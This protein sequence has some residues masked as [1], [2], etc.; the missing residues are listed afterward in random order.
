MALKKFYSSIPLLIIGF[1]ILHDT[2]PTGS[3]HTGLDT[4]LYRLFLFALYFFIILLMYIIELFSYFKYEEKIN[5][6][7]ICI[8]VL[9]VLAQYVIA[10]FYPHI[11]GKEIMRAENKHSLDRITIILRDNKTCDIRINGADV[12]VTMRDVYHIDYDTLKIPKINSRMA[13][14]QLAEMYLIDSAKSLMYP[15]DDKISFQDST[16]WLKIVHSH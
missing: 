5:L 8:T 2:F 12:G 16:K 15:I 10:L 11:L 7:P 3:W 14:G 1:L 6:I 9:S 13:E 4:V